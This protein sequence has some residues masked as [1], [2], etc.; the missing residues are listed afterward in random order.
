VLQSW[1]RKLLRQVLI[2]NNSSEIIPHQLTLPFPFLNIKVA[3]KGGD[4]GISVLS[5]VH[6]NSGKL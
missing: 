4:G 2:T 5:V 1:K 3:R 6:Y